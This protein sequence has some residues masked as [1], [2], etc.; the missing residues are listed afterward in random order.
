MTAKGMSPNMNL[1]RKIALGAGD[2]GF[3]LYWQTASLYLLFFYTDVLGL[4]AAT[5]GTIYMA[6]L[7]VDALLDPL[8][9]LLADRTRSR[10][11]R[12]RPY[13]LFG[14]IPLGLLFAAMFMGPA[15]GDT[16]SVV[17]AAATHIAFR[18]IYAVIS[19]PYASLFARVTRDA[20]VRTNLTAFRMVFATL[21]AVAVAALT[22]PVVKA[23]S[24]PEAPRH[25]WVVLAVVFGT[26]ATLILLL[27]AWATKGY[28]ADETAEP[29]VVRPPILAALRSVLANRALLVVLGS[30]VISSFCNT[31]FGKNLVY[32]FKYVIGKA[33]LAGGALAFVAL[34]AALCVPLWALVARRVGKRNAWLLGS[35][36]GI[37]GLLLWH[38][39]DGVVPLL[40]VALS[41]QAISTGAYIVSYWSMLPDT[42]EY[43]EWRTGVRTESMVFGLATLG[44]KAALGLGAGFLGLALSHVGYAPNATQSPETLEG[45]K[46]M[47]FWFPLIG[48]LISAGLVALYP[49]DLAAHRRIVEEIA[50]R[51]S[52]ASSASM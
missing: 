41:L 10:Y 5:A 3:N 49:M 8:M 32:Y 26:L 44:Q 27:V 12:Y 25:G 47:M 50:Q 6:A 14:G 46:Q 30:V 13:L 37:A 52:T 33:E 34:L 16:A 48:G 39:G 42:V 4:P 40:F 35:I 9:G 19:I 2:F 23:L 29:S 28:D 36:P 17:F 7:I 51:T 20:Q 31:L 11:G 21:S 1:G 43:G 15:G 45:I 18:T 24:T 22:L 38:F